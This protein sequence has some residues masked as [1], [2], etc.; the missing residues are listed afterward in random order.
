MTLAEA[1]AVGRIIA[2]ADSGCGYCIKDLAKRCRKQWP[3]F[4]WWVDGEAD[5]GEAVIVTAK[6]NEMAQTT[7]TCPPL[8]DNTKRKPTKKG[9]R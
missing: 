4:E 9:K 7:G 3:Q 6:E 5:Y 1:Q 8:H 2:T